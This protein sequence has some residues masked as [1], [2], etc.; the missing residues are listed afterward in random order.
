MYD[1]RTKIN[2][3]LIYYTRE[4]VVKICKLIMFPRRPCINLFQISL[5]VY[6]CTYIQFLELLV[7]QERPIYFNGI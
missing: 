6:V 3:R 5:D 4:T 2:F 7:W 1:F